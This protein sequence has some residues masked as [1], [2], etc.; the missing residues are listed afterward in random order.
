MVKKKEGGLASSLVITNVNRQLA[1]L[2]NFCQPVDLLYDVQV[3]TMG[4]H[5]Q[6]GCHVAHVSLC[7]IDES[8]DLA[9]LREH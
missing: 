4:N 1:P 2:E 9:V 6:N 5:W 8:S 3:V 7:L